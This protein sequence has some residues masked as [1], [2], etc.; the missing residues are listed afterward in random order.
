MKHSLLL[1]AFTI[2]TL[3]ASA[4]LG[5]MAADINPGEISVT[6][7]AAH[8]V[9]PS[10]ALLNLG[11]SSKNVSVQS[12][13]SHNDTIMSK[14]ISSLQHLGVSRNN[15][16]TSNITINPNYDYIDGNSK[17]NGY[18]VNNTV[19]VRIYDTA[20]IG[21]AIDAAIASGASDINSLTFQTDVSQ[22][23]E[24]QLST[25]AIND[26]RHQAE[27]IAK[28]LGRELGPV[29]SAS[30]GTTH[31]QTMEVNPRYAM[32]AVKSMDLSSSTPVEKG[33]MAANKTANVVFYLQ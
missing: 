11:V 4:T 2:G 27:V 22:E 26:A 14:L 24:D 13:K 7:Q 8:Q 32:L 19:V 10:Y 3:M 28:S 21:K 12:A 29:K 18:N 30:L 1:K 25:S 23:M 20:S 33:D 5:T 6:G 9:A 16:Q 17:L 15:I 31:T